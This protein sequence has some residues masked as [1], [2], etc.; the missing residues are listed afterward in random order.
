MAGVNLECQVYADIVG[1]KLRYKGAVTDGASVLWEGKW[2]HSKEDAIKEAD[3]NAVRI[4]REMRRR[5]VH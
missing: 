5:V 2:R 4:D 3:Q 1:G